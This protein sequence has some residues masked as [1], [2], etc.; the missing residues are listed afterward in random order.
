VV[1]LLQTLAYAAKVLDE[2]CE[3]LDRRLPANAGQ[4]HQTHRLASRPELD[5]C[6]AFLRPEDMLI[7]TKLDRLGRSVRNWWS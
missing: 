7:I 3:S 4:A 6:L 2:H 1:E 5:K